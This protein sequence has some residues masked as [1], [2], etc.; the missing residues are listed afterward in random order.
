ME[1]MLLVTDGMDQAKTALPR[2]VEVSHKLDAVSGA[3]PTHVVSTLVFGGLQPILGY[4]NFPDVVKNSALTVVNLHK[5]ITSQ[6]EA[7]MNKESERA[8]TFVEDHPDQAHSADEAQVKLRSWPKRLHVCFD[9]AVGE[10]INQNVF[11]YLSSLVH[12]GIFYRITVGTFLV[13]HTHNI[14]DQLFSVWSKYLDHND[15]VTPSEMKEAFEKHYHGYVKETEQEEKERLDSNS[16]SSVQVSSTGKPDSDED[17]D[18][19]YTFTGIKRTPKERSKARLEVMQALVDEGCIASPKIEFTSVNAHIGGWFPPALKRRDGLKNLKNYHEFAFAKDPSTGQTL[20][21]RKFLQNSEDLYSKHPHQENLDGTFYRSKDVI[22]EK[23][24]RLTNDPVA[25]PFNYVDTSSLDSMIEVLKTEKGLNGT[26]E[27]ELQ[28]LSTRLKNQVLQ[29]GVD[30]ET[31][32]TF[33]DAIGKIGSISR[34]PGNANDEEKKAYRGKLK[35]R[36]DATEGLHRHLS[37]ESQLD[38]HKNLSMDG[39]WQ[40]WLTR[41]V[42]LISAHYESRNISSF[43]HSPDSLGGGEVP[44]GCVA[45]PPDR[46]ISESF[47]FDRV[48]NICFTTY[49]EPAVGDMVVIRYEREDPLKPPF[50]LGIV[51]AYRN[52]TEADLQLE[53]EVK[54]AANDRLEGKSTKFPTNAVGLDLPDEKRKDKEASKVNKG[55]CKDSMAPLAT[56]SLFQYTHVLIDWI[57]HLEPRR[58]KQGYGKKRKAR[59]KIKGIDGD[60]NKKMKSTHF[61]TLPQVLS[62]EEERKDHDNEEEQENDGEDIEEDEDKDEDCDKED[63]DKEDEEYLPETQSP[64][65]DT[66]SLRNPPRRVVSFVPIPAKEVEKFKNFVYVKPQHAS[67]I[68]SLEKLSTIQQA[69][70]LRNLSYER[71]MPVSSLLWWSRSSFLTASTSKINGDTWRYIMQ[72][73]TTP[74]EVL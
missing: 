43:A 74:R 71:W 48:Q 29:Q 11:L 58:K 57:I 55:H 65:E 13:G 1:V 68:E 70:S 47:K 16:I 19:E 14:N 20:L 64:N 24:E 54:T 15:V 72:D 51:R 40:D 6:F 10:N 5:A 22:F 28:A 4:I 36:K 30:C 59:K 18:E 49:K 53:M 25:L 33:I 12:H 45:H 31:C 9:N 42:P 56:S 60:S 26:Q 34:P 52:V 41:R 8:R 69:C 7:I 32:K 37:D 66:L 23:D 27:S 17:S 21:Y 61:E 39:W 3:L 35:E 73:L 50:G 67:D 38:K 62:Q 44:R 2:K 46:S 63:D